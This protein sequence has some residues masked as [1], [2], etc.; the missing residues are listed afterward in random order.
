[1]NPLTHMTHTVGNK[2]ENMGPKTKMSLT[3]GAIALAAMGGLVLAHA[4]SLI[5]LQHITAAVAITAV[6]IGGVGLIAFAIHLIKEKA[7][8]QKFQKMDAFFQ[9][10][11]LQ[12]LKGGESVVIPNAKGEMIAYYKTQGF[13]GIGYDENVDHICKNSQV[14]T[15]SSLI[16]RWSSPSA[17]PRV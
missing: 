6:S 11:V 13:D 10:Q 16:A 3:I 4:G 15:L 9:G 12:E 17:P 7:A 5:G 2:I 8:Q 1:M 14:V